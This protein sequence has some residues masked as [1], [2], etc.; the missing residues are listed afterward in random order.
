MIENR[1]EFQQ[2]NSDLSV[3][4]HEIHQRVYE[5]I[6]EVN[7]TSSAEVFIRFPS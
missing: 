1:K 4:N 5:I 2:L 7:A 3:Y 6:V